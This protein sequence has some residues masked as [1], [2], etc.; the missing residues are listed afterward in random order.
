MTPRGPSE[1]GGTAADL[2]AELEG[3]ADFVARRDARERDRRAREREL[4]AAEAPLLA[5]LRDAG[6]EVDSVWDLVNT[7]APYPRAVPILLEHLGRDHPDRVRE[8][9]GRALAVPEARPYWEALLGLYDREP[10]GTDA[11][12]GLAAALGATA[13]DEVLPDL[14]A[15]AEDD[16]HGDSRLLLL[17]A[18]ERSGDPRARMALERLAEDPGLAPEARRILGRA[19]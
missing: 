16:R 9:I 10:A 19:G 18:L 6:C 2:L 4:R 7:A 13:D 1:G 3:D 14:M 12:V 17:G 15:R 8:G 5:A 11:K